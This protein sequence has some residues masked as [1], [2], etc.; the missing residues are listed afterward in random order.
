MDSLFINS[1][2]EDLK[3]PDETV[4][5]EAT[6]K[7]WRIWFQQKGVHGLEVI[8][9]SQKFID[10]GK[11]TEA[12]AVLT[13][14][15]NDQPDFAEAWNRRAFLYYTN[16]EYRKSLADCQMVVKINPIH[17]GALHGMGL[18]FAAMGEYREAIRAFHRALEIQPYSQVNQKLI[19]ECTLRLN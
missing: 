1:L 17:F 18:C 11:I 14:L 10:S 9:R 15:V 13:E 8:E 6:R 5:D 19:L 2:L 7:I 16:C 12:E 4:R 3:N